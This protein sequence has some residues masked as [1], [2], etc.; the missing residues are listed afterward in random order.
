MKVF[1]L[2]I[3]A[4]LPAFATNPPVAK[5]QGIGNPSAPILIELYSDFECPACREFH[6]DM[7]PRLMR[8][9]INTGKVYLVDHDMSNHQHSAEATGY[10][11]AA[12]RIG[13][14][15]DVANALFQHQAEWSQNGKVWDAVASVL[16]AADQK[17][18]AAMAKEPSIQAE[19]KTETDDGRA[20]VTQTPT[21]IVIRSMRQYRFVGSPNYDLFSGFLNDLLKK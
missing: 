5:G 1:A 8:D 19:I 13:K 10:A 9:F 16:S 4:L 17:K 2:L 11:F 14:Y 7:L 12:A 6:V 21:M 20:K 3:A 18:V 15:S